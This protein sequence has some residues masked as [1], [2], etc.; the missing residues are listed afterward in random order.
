MSSV[1][2]CEKTSPTVTASLGGRA[3]SCDVR[4]LSRYTSPFSDTY[5]IFFLWYPWKKSFSNCEI[6]NSFRRLPPFV[7]SDYCVPLFNVRY[8][9][10]IYIFFLSLKKKFPSSLCSLWYN[11]GDWN[12]YVA[13]EFDHVVLQLAYSILYFLLLSSSYSLLTSYLVIFQVR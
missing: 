12:S 13:H 10:P 2:H 5:P 3:R 6:I 1:V 4:F 9:A 8:L 7:L 11:G